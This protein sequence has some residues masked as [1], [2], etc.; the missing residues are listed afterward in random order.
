MR[1]LVIGSH[2]HIGKH[3]NIEANCDIGDYCLIANRVAIVGRH[4]HDFSA[5]GFPMRYAPWIGSKRFSS[6]YADE[7]TVIESVVRL[8]FGLTVLAGV[9]VGRGSVAAVG[10]AVTSSTPPPVSE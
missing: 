10:C 5:V 6:P 2:V 8:G 9:T 4:D 1:R 3:V 7:K